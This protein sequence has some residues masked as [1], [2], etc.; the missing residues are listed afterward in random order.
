MEISVILP[1]EIVKP[2]TETGRPSL[3]TTAPAAPLTSTGWTATPG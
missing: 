2:M 1:P 3:V